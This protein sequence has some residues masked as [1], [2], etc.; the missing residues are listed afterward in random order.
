[1]QYQYM[2]K[3]LGRGICIANKCRRPGHGRREIGESC[4]IKILL[5]YL[6]SERVFFESE[7]VFFSYSFSFVKNKLA[8]LEILQVYFASS[9]LKLCTRYLSPRC[10]FCG[11][12]RASLALRTPRPTSSTSGRK[13][14]CN[15]TLHTFVV[16]GSIFDVQ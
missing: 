14:T 4:E 15:I 9:S 11:G 7:R 10:L 2:L 13:V 5:A 8:D 12:N 16:V 1:M 3:I 6:N